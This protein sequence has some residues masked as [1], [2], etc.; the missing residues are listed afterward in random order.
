MRRIIG[1]LLVVSATSLGF[2][3]ATTTT[4]SHITDL[5]EA[6]TSIYEFFAADTGVQ[7]EIGRADTSW[8]DRDY[9]YCQSVSANISVNFKI[10]DAPKVCDNR[11]S[12]LGNPGLN[13]PRL[14]VGQAVHSGGITCVIFR[15]DVTCHDLEG[16]GFMMTRDHISPLLP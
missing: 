9:A 16:N 4:S 1:V 15:S 8:V 7:C 2:I 10:G 6:P 3:G 13:T 5:I 14:R 12:C 11:M